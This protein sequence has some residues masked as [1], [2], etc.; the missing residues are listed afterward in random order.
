ML[1]DDARRHIHEIAHKFPEPEFYRVHKK[2]TARA[3]EMDRSS[4]LVGESRKMMEAHGDPLGHGFYHARKV[5]IDAAAIVYAE[6][7]ISHI[8]DCLATDALLA[9]YIHD[10]K[11]DQKAHPRKA[12]EFFEQHFKDQMNPE[13]VEMISFAIRNHEAF[14]EP[15]HTTHP[16]KK[17]LS[18]ALYDADKFRWGPDNFLYTI[19]DMAASMNLTPRQIVDGYDHGIRGIRRIRNTFRTQTGQM[20]GP[21]FIDI[22]LMMGE[23]L[24]NYLQE[25]IDN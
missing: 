11:R 21:G 15:V 20:F 16:H 13:Q 24:I 12:A 8:A 7:G 9:G 14:V 10:I 6:T 19:W 1:L 17:L 23:E 2:E 4:P 25:G 3:H 22:G 18:D 5:A